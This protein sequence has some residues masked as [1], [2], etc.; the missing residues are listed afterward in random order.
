MNSLR[1]ATS[2]LGRIVSRRPRSE[3]QRQVNLAPLQLEARDCPAVNLIANPSVETQS[4]SGPPVAWQTNHYGTNNGTFTYL[5]TGL[6]GQRSLRVDLTSYKSGDAKW[7][8]NDVPV[9]PGQ[10]YSFSDL[11]TSNVAT[12]ATVRYRMS[13]G[14]FRY[15]GYYPT[16]AATGGTFA[17][18]F[19]VPD[20]AV[21]A[22][23]FHLLRTK[24]Y[25]ITDGFSL[26]QGTTTPDTTAPAVSVTAPAANANVSG[27][28][29]L[30]ANASD[31]VGVAGV[32]FF[33]DGNVVGSE[34]TAAPY[35][36]SLDTKT[37]TNGTHLVTAVA[38]DAAGNSATSTAVSITVNNLAPDTTAPTVSLTAPAAD[39][40]LVGTVSLTADAADNVGVVG[41]KFLVDGNLVGSE[42]TSAPYAVSLDTTA[43]TNGT[44]SVTAVARDAA[45]NETT[46]AAVS[47]TVANPTADTTAPTVSVTAPAANANV[48]DSINLTADAADN[49]GVVGVKFLVDGNLV[50][51]EDLTAPYEVSL[52]TKTLTNGT[53]SITAIARDA[54]GNSTTST[55]VSVTVANVIPDTTA[56]TVSVTAPAADANVS[57]TISLTANAADDVGVAGV[58][59]LV[60]GNPVGSEDTDSPYQVS[61]DTA[62]LTN[63]AHTITAVARDAAGNSTTS[64]AISVTVAN[65]VPDTTAPTVSVT[66][67]AAGANLD[68][69]INLTADAA[70]NIGVVG[71]KFLVDGNLVGSED[72]AAPYQVSLD[73]TTL[74]NGTHSVTA[75]ARD[76]AGNETTSAAVSV[77]IANPTQTPTN[78]IPNPSVE[79]LGSNGDPVGWSR[80]SWGTNAA[81]F[82]PNVAGTDG[83]RGVRVE[84]TSYTDGDAKWY[85]NPITVAPNTTYTFSDSYRS[86]RES[87]LVAQITATNGTLSYVWL[88]TLGANTNWTNASVQLTTPANAASVTIFHLI[89][90]VGWLETDKFALIAGTNGG[91]GG[92]G[93][94]GELTNGMV[95]FAF[96][97]GWI[98]QLQNALPALQQA[99]MP[100]SFYV[101][102]RANQGGDS[103]EYVQNRS[104]ETA[105]AA[106]NPADWFQL[107]TGTSTANFNYATVGSDGTRS[108]RIDVTSYTSGYNS[109]YFQDVAV[110]PGTQYTIT[111]DYSSNVS[112]SEFVRFTLHDGSSVFV[113]Q[114]SIDTTNG[115]WQS[116]TITVTAPAN[117]DAMTVVHR[118]S[119]VGSLS[120]DN[121]SVKEVD[122]FSNPSYFSPAQI[123]QL[124][125]AGYEIGVHTM[126][127]S[128][129]PSLST[130]GALA[131]ID[132]AR[133]DL[134]NLGINPTTFVYPYGS[135]NTEIEQMVA[136]DGFIGARTVNEGLN[137][138]ASDPFALMHH[139]VDRDTTV[140]QVQAWIDEAVATKSWLILTFHQI[141]NSSDYYGTTPQTFQQIVNMVAQ[142][143]LTPV[144]VEDGLAQ[145]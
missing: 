8:F 57:G 41:V 25:L 121:F 1:S 63:G 87:K 95:S 98:S 133:E 21:S 107:H 50:G 96:D 19:T 42:D 127:H 51:S 117:A 123:Q 104:F 79:D 20:K 75:V 111:H 27:S 39:A 88:A 43:L 129:L 141:D 69:T 56:P 137:T 124:A 106:G 92:G 93:G 7:Y 118:I 115:Q 44:H 91:G 134:I 61:L 64:A 97:D 119:Q 112:T 135:Y 80:S 52:D 142:S 2:L 45:G 5:T 32:R 128:D 109:W 122:P 66:A 90:G 72:L 13:D 10:T 40:N 74:T 113:D 38:R 54:A 24:G 77:T 89:E 83:D 73:T 60:D 139:E 33:V 120:V 84:M 108:G 138:K 58:T 132:G 14:K 78:L 48:S 65:V 101:I 62:T 136:N 23:V 110:K 67:P 81:T 102:S 99:N 26:T 49:V 85:F 140:A 53:H 103:W 86:N 130:A 9:T 46:S 125:A 100:A 36:V 47:V 114:G 18:N 82:T 22:T 59:F 6:D 28:I 37:L 12:S 94:G 4:A 131:E 31:N 144:T 126:T 30:T 70:D 68:G 29:D 55:A 3:R 76:A 17:F 143:N 116:Q 16:P 11:Y 145:L 105:T 35:Q 34:D 15:I 71:V